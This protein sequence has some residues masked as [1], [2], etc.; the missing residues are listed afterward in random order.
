MIELK[1]IEKKYRESSNVLFIEH[2]QIRAGEVTAVLGANGSGKTTLLKMMMG[3]GEDSMPYG[4]ALV[5]GKPVQEQYEKLAFITEE[6]SYFPR[7]TAAQYGVFLGDYFP[8]FNR[9]RYEQLLDF[10]ELKHDVRIKTMS[11]GQRSKLEI[12]AGFAKGAKYILMDEPF[13]GK[14]MFTRRDFLKLMVSSLKDDE[15]IIITSHLIDE[16]EN[17]IDRAIILHNGRIRADVMIDELREQDGSLP[18]LMA[19]KAGYNPDKYK[20]LLNT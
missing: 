13:N 20:D 18:Q 9:A 5:D 11:T 3:L 8:R 16:L 19:E 10:F 4:I 15:A 1:L 2:L 6:G 12:C 17:V 14:D 7:M